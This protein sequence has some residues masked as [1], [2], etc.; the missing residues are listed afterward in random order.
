[1][2]AGEPCGGGGGWWW[3]A[4]RVARRG[5][6]CAFGSWK[7]YRAHTRTTRRHGL[8]YEWRKNAGRGHKL[9][10][11]WVLFWFLLLNFTKLH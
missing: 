1:M 7:R 11:T 3:W 8:R 6:A 5:A 4:E 10:R 2:I 9:G